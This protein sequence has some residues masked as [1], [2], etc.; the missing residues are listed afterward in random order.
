M[1]FSMT[2]ASPSVIWHITRDGTPARPGTAPGS[3]RFVHCSFTEQLAGT[4]ALHF[5]G[6]DQ[7]V[8]LRLDSARLGARLVLE[9]SRDGALFPHVY[10]EIEAADILA[11]V[12]VRRGRNQLF[13]LAALPG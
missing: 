5:V 11:R 9:P 13:D 3:E 1:L 6:V 8:L 7:V 10:G 12:T 4:L 2:S